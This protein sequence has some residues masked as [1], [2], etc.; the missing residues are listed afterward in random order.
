MRRRERGFTLLEVL[1]AVALLGILYTVLAG[2]AIQGL[3]AEGVSRRRFEASLLADRQLAEL[4]LEMDLGSVPSE[5]VT[6]TEE[7]EFLVTVSVE[8]YDPME[9]LPPL[10]GDD[11]SESLIE[12]LALL[13]PGAEA[14]VRRIDVT[15][16]WLEAGDE[17]SVERTTFGFDVNSV[18]SLMARGGV[19]PEL[20]QPQQQNS[21]DPSSPQDPLP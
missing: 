9:Y 21:L 12:V 14:P 5:G 10:E 15:V 17:Y 2:V 13:T 19:L 4:E 3:R 1:A 11:D 6:E 18:A 20:E 16:S 7:E 8:P